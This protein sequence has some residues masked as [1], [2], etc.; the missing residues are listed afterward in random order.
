MNFEGG[1]VGRKDGVVE[2]IAQFGIF[3]SEPGFE[4]RPGFGEGWVRGRGRGEWCMQ[5]VMVQWEQGGLS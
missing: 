5:R 3:T 1:E 2:G 4:P